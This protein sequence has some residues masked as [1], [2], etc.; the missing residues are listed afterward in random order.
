[1]KLTKWLVGLL[2]AVSLMFAVGCSKDD[3][4]GKAAD[5]AWKEA[6]Y[7]KSSVKCGDCGAGTWKCVKPENGCLIED[8]L[9]CEKADCEWFDIGL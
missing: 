1:M 3:D 8:M 4:N 9:V 6:G 2:M 5:A 7:E